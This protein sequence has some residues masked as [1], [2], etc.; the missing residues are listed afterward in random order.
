MFISIIADLRDRAEL[1]WSAVK[2]T[3]HLQYKHQGAYARRRFPHLLTHVHQGKITLDI[4]AHKGVITDSVRRHDPYRLLYM[5]EADPDKFRRLRNTFS[6]ITT[7]P[8][9][10]TDFDGEVEFF[11]NT[12]RSGFSSLTASED[13][14][15]VT[16]QARKLDSIMPE[17]KL[18]TSVKIDVEGHELAVL[19]G[20]EQ[21]IK[22]CQPVI[23]FESGPNDAEP[24]NQLYDW[25]DVRD[26][27][28][29][30]PTRVERAGQV[31]GM[32]RDEFNSYHVWP[33][34]SF[35]YIAVPK[36]WTP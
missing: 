24:H 36:S 14:R 17:I 18:V 19:R 11:I 32:S 31:P 6:G 1:V 5:F 2:G 29:Y 13:A 25:F 16:V 15:K 30:L 28:I 7:Y 35:D 20:A 26:Y 12:K 3:P 27:R 23:M 33:F 8:Y 4:G 21:L 34:P 22:R 10:L 9:A